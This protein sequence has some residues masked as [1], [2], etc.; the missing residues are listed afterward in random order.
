MV[1]FVSILLIQNWFVQEYAGVSANVIS[2]KYKQEKKRTPP[3]EKA[4]TVS[5]VILYINEPVTKDC[6]IAAKIRVTGYARL[7]IAI[8]NLLLQHSLSWER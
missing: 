3:L 8:W 5:E 7:L 6:M 4:P 1:Q 2:A